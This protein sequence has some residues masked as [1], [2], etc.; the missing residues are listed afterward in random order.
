MS[1]YIK[2]KIAKIAL[3]LLVAV[4]II[5][6]LSTINLNTGTDKTNITNTTSTTTAIVTTVGEKKEVVDTTTSNTTVTTEKIT[7]VSAEETQ[8][9]TQETASAQKSKSSQ[10]EVTTAETEVRTT[11]TTQAET[12][13]I[14]GY[15]T[16][17][18]GEFKLTAYFCDTWSSGYTAS[19]TVP[20]ANHTI[21]ASK[22]YPFGTKFLINGVVY[23]VEDRGGAI[24][25]NILDVYFNT[26]DE[27][28]NFGVQYADV[29]L[30]VED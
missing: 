28:I 24:Q 30:I 21:A 16:T 23:T 3:S 8:T 7:D 15:T 13:N 25:G 29:Y 5:G 22:E 1:D 26:Y 4:G 18:L 10:T 11:T 20:Q 19:G 2:L 6:A 12:E 14:D 27:C 9:T 17:Y